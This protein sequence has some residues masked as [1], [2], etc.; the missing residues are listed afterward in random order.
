MRIKTT[1]AREERVESS[2]LKAEMYGMTR[3][4]LIELTGSGEFVG[5]L[6]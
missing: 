6:A 5:L 2:W 3:F 1:V 4:G